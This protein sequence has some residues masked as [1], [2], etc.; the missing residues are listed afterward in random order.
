MQGDGGMGMSSDWLAQVTV[1]DLTK[2]GVGGK[3]PKLSLTPTNVTGGI[4]ISNHQHLTTDDL[5]EG[6]RDSAENQD[7]KSINCD[8]ERI[9]VVREEIATSRLKQEEMSQEIA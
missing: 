8:G 7:N 5:Q 6:Q 4:G 1:S 9:S 2:S 3:V